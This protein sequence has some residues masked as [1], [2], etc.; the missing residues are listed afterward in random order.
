MF[1]DSFS[2]ILRDCDGEKRKKVQIMIK[3][4]AQDIMVK[5]DTDKNDMLDWN[6]FKMYFALGADTKRDEVAQYLTKF[7]N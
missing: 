3:A 5:M 7:F 1:M 2:D 6:E 4:L